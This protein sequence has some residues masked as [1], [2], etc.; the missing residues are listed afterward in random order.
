M[1]K[2]VRKL[3]TIIMNMVRQRH[4][5]VGGWIATLTLPLKGKVRYSEKSGACGAGDCNYP[6]RP[7]HGKCPAM[8]SDHAS[9]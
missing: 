9:L 3:K 4:V 8:D 6:Q 2:S 5:G 7:D 1:P